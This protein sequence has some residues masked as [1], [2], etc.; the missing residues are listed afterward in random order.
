M[1]KC[2]VDEAIAVAATRTVMIGVGGGHRGSVF[3]WWKLVA[4]FCMGEVSEEVSVLEV[5]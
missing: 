2:R 4:L 1:V 3:V 5:F